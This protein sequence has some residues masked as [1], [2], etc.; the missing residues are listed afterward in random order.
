MNLKYLDEQRTENHNKMEEILESAKKE[1]R[2]LSEDEISKF[3][4]LKKLIGEIDATIKAEEESRE[5]DIEEKKE[6]K[7]EETKDNVE[8]DNN[9]KSEERAFTEYIISG[10]QR[11]NSPGMSYGSNGAIVPTTIAKKIIEKVK[12]L[13]PIY[14]KVEKFTTKGTLEIP[15]YD[16]DSDAT[17]PTGDVNVAYQ[18]D[19]FTALVAGQG[20]FTSV[21]LKGYSHGALSVISRKL[22]N[23]EDINVTSFLTNKMAQAFAEFWEKELL[24]GTGA[25]N[26]HMTGAISTTNLV[27]TGNTTYTAASAAKID[28]LINLQLAVPQQYQKNAMWIMNKAVFT[29][30]RKLKDGSGNY[31]LAYGKGITEGFDWQLLGKPVYISENMPAATTANNIPILYGD[32]AGMAM[33]ISQNL[34]IQLMREKYIDKNAIGIVGWAECDSKIQNNQRIA[35]LKMATSV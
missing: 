12:E 35:G 15:V 14:D 4:E 27:A 32:F 10:K 18:G 33:K 24:V 29:E 25:T 31:Y 7:N 16:T 22:L 9:V 17:S 13:S 23:N 20:K 26:N 30:L 21:E 8:K 34:E 5:M 28:N 2:A 6:N 19:E 1:E 11:A 3:N